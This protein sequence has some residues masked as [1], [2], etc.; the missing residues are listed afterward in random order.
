MTVSYSGRSTQNAIDPDSVDATQSPE[1]QYAH[2]SSDEV[3]PT[4]LVPISSDE[5]PPTL[6]VP[7]LLVP[8]LAQLSIDVD[9]LHPTPL[10]G[11]PWKQCISILEQDGFDLAFHKSV[12]EHSDILE[13]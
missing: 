1:E 10:Y 8:S 5:V 7:T 9:V 6:L 4:L 2:S 11:I 13:A 3:P 12:M